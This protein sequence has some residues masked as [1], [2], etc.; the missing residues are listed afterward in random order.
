MGAIQSCH[1]FSLETIQVNGTE[2]VEMYDY[3][4]IECVIRLWCLSPIGCIGM[5]LNLLVLWVWTGRQDQP[6]R[7]LI[8]FL[9]CLAVF[10]I[11]YLILCTG[12]NFMLNS[13]SGRYLEVFILF[14]NMIVFT[15]TCIALY[16]YCTVFYPDTAAKRFTYRCSSITIAAYFLLNT[17]LI[18]ACII[19]CKKSNIQV[20]VAIIGIIFLLIPTSIQVILVARVLR[21][22][23]RVKKLNRTQRRSKVSQM[24]GMGMEDKKLRDE[25]RKAHQQTMAVCHVVLCSFMAFGLM[26]FLAIV[27]ALMNMDQEESA[28]HRLF[29]AR[30]LG[31]RYVNSSINFTIFFFT[32]AEFR[33][34][35]RKKI[36]SLCPLLISS[37][38][39][40]EIH[41]TSDIPPS[42]SNRIHPFPE[43]QGQMDTS[44]LNSTPCTKGTATSHLETTHI[45]PTTGASESEV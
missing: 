41:T 3:K 36:S 18:I 31:V 17:L 37:G 9:K 42:D 11:F 23:S 44:K 27:Y 20:W 43:Q 40:T 4:Y 13:G 2:K 14:Q 5:V 45:N 29:K 26:T 24:S 32:V 7:P 1:E 33:S 16:Q 12:R 19:L 15:T 6:F 39:G 28:V 21:K 34:L 22:I 25:R 38:S 30:L 10:D 35:F 8:Y